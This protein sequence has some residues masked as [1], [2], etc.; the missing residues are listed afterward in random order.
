MS[1]VYKCLRNKKVKEAAVGSAIL[2]DTIIY[3]LL[4]FSLMPVNG[5][6]HIKVQKFILHDIITSEK[7][8]ILFQLHNV[9][10][11]LYFVASLATYQLNVAASV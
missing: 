2:L 11:S 9:K 3:I 6:V 1:E 7:Q 8:M 5:S 10:L 4:Q